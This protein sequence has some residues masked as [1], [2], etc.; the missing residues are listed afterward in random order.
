[1]TRYPACKHES[2]S[3]WLIRKSNGAGGG[4][5]EKAKRKKCFKQLI[6]FD[7][8]NTVNTCMKNNRQIL[9]FGAIIKHVIQTTFIIMYATSF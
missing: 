2:P 9:Q 8:N 6:S 3:Q 7:I 4:G 5:Q 1:M